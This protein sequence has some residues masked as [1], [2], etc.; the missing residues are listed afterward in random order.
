MTVTVQPSL[1]KQVLPCPANTQPQLVEQSSFNRPE[2]TDCRGSPL[3]EVAAGVAFRVFH[4]NSGPGPKCE[5]SNDER[6]H[7]AF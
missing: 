7:D 6:A 2:G 4:Q 1:Q 3:D 5:M